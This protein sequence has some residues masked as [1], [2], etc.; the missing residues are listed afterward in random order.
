[1]LAALEPKAAA[2]RH[3]HVGCELELMLQSFMCAKL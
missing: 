2:T 1:M 3:V